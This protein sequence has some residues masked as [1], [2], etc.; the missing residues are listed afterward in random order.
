MNQ[1]HSLSSSQAAAAQRPT[2]LT[3]PFNT[4]EDEYEQKPDSLSWTVAP[5]ASEVSCLN[6]V[7]HYI[8]IFLKFIWPP[9]FCNV[10]SPGEM[11]EMLAKPEEI[12]PQLDGLLD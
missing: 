7:L 3:W 12:T 2:Y 10:W 8:I 6:L 11:A 9:E 4:L 5:P 1:S